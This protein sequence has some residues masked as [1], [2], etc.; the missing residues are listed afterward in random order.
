MMIEV[1]VQVTEERIPE[2]YKMFGHWLAGTAGD[3]V[4][5]DGNFAE[6]AD[7]PDDLALA[8]A[9]WGKLS[10]TAKAMFTVMLE[11]PER[12]ISGEQLAADLGI[13]NGKYGVAGALAWPGR[14]CTAV[15]RPPAV[16]YIDGPVG[17][18]ADYWMTTTVASLFDKARTA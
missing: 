9:V 14:H 11:S 12:K 1:K 2:F 8:R 16:Q 3:E 5:S 6:W 10:A 13:P 4:E 7:T 15:G 18:S 17:G